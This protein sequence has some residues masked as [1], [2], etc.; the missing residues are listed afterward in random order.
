MRTR[1]LSA[2]ADERIGIVSGQAVTLESLAARLAAANPALLGP[3]FMAATA[4]LAGDVQAGASEE[5]ARQA[6]LADVIAIELGGAF[7][8]FG[9]TQVLDLP[10][11]PRSLRLRERGAALA[12]RKPLSDE[13]VPPASQASL[14]VD[15]S[16]E[17]TLIAPTPERVWALTAFTEQVDL[18][19]E[20]HYRLTPTSISAALESGTE[21][22]Q[23]TKL[24]QRGSRKPLPAE[25]TARLESWARSFRNARLQRAIVVSFED[26][27]E[28]EA[29]LNA[30]AGRDWR[31]EALGALS[32]LVRRDHAPDGSTIEEEQLVAALRGAGF[33][34]TW[35]KG[36]GGV[37]PGVPSAAATW[38]SIDS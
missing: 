29:I 32:V 26:A 22:G 34:P 1:L 19:R 18:G 27:G 25:L 4:R 36:N 15:A 30:L 2:L 31:V 10:G 14:L 5:E 12:A 21:I 16:G 8:W 7:I 13:P 3:S 28:Q 9:V 6:A 17:I 35:T 20:S 33:V 38:R 23:I 37:D 11:Q 24:L